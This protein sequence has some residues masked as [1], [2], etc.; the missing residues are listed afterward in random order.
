MSESERTGRE[1]DLEVSQINFIILF[2]L[3]K[4]VRSIMKYITYCVANTV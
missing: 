2:T 1:G 3:T 4:I